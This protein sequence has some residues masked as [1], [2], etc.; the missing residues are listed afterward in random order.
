MVTNNGDSFQNP[1]AII[2]RFSLRDTQDRHFFAAEQMLG[3]GAT[4]REEAGSHAVPVATFRYRVTRNKP[5]TLNPG[6]LA[7][8]RTA[9][10]ECI[11]SVLYSY[12]K[13]GVPMRSAQ[14]K[15]AIELIVAR[16]TLA[17]RLALQLRTES[18]G[19]E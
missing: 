11:V 12:A 7:S 5:V 17:Q 19:V 1:T 8:L 15:Q 4:Y 2:S 10:K 18:P 9:E 6:L 13:R 14:L 3:R 16:M